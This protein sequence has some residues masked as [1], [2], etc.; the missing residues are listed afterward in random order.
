[1]NGKEKI[2]TGYR[3]PAPRPLASAFDR[4]DRCRMAA[5]AAA[6]GGVLRATAVGFVSVFSRSPLHPV[7]TKASNR[8]MIRIRGLLNP[9]FESQ[10]RLAHRDLPTLAAAIHPPANQYR[11]T[12]SGPTL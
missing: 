6:T 7:N 3:T 5:N 1:M 9:T 2:M 4:G 10:N 8:A 12:S 11:R